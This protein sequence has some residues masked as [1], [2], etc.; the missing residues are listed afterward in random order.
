MIGTEVAEK[1]LAGKIGTAFTILRP[2]GKVEI[3]GDVYD[4]TAET[5]YIDKGEK[6]E[7][8]RFETAQLF[9]RKA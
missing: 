4:A 5:G 1:N 3:D 2:S 6:I 8:V 7:V 9:V